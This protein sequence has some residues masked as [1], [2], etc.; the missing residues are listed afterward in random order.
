MHLIKDLAY[1]ILYFVSI[2]RSSEPEELLAKS[3]A[4][5]DIH[6]YSFYSFSFIFL[7]QA[8]LRL[9][10]TQSFYVATTEEISVFFRV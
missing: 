8:V 6:F 2:S 3:F 10:Y 4:Y 1:N 9:W 7:L 5:F